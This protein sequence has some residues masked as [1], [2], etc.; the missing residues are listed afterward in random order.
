MRAL[1]FALLFCAI[2]RAQSQDARQ[3]TWTG[4]FAD[5]RCARARL[6]APVLTKTN[7]DC[8]KA[9]LEKGAAP[10]FISEQAHAVFA[11]KN[12]AA[13]AEN[14]GYHLEVSGA[15]DESAKTM[16]IES[17]KRISEY[18]GPACSRPQKKP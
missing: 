4:W 8:A 14:I 18:E 2:A 11:V 12:Y 1:R 7:P 13:I 6:T 15:V 17:V 5:D 9:C 16:S 3:V 10:V